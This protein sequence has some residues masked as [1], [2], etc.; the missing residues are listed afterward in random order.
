MKQKKKIQEV[1]FCVDN[2]IRDLPSTV[3]ICNFLSIKN[4]K[5]RII[6]IGEE[7]NSTYKGHCLF[8]YP[9][10]TYSLIS[11]ITLKS[12]GH[13]VGVLEVEGNNQD[14]EI[15]YKVRITPDFWCFWNEAEYKKYIYLSKENLYL[16]FSGCQ[17]LDLL[18]TSYSHIFNNLKK[19][20][21]I[22]VLTIALSSQDTHF[23]SEKL[24]YKTERRRKKFSKAA[25]YEAVV[26]N[27]LELRNR[28][29]KLIK[30]VLENT[31]LQIILRP[32]PNENIL[33]W[34]EFMKKLD[35][36]SIKLSLDEYF[37]SFI[38]KSDLHLAFN[39]CTTTVEA[40]LIGLKTIELQT[41]ESKKLYGHEHLKLA[42]YNSLS[43]ESDFKVLMSL[44]RNKNYEEK[45][46]IKG[47]NDFDFNLYVESKY[48]KFDGLRCKEI[49]KEIENFISRSFKKKNLFFYKLFSQLI[50]LFSELK[51]LINTKYRR[52]SIS[53]QNAEVIDYNGINLYKN[54]GIISSNQLK[55]DIELWRNLL[56]N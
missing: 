46:L 54:H 19:S 14:K 7:L 27:Q 2:K 9:K 26:K 48:G 40:R 33:Y 39:V 50:L 15:E 28:C 37:N 20:R 4:I 49:S 47:I 38:N 24:K 3:Q 16:C 56:K 52:Q 51:K 8:I 34:I 31:D 53:R 36:A 23:N 1:I 42:N 18:H 25:D 22:K 55:N 45:S 35:N 17:R 11:V 21:D 5:N 29:E 43:E 32:H 44:I 30:K 10:V 12:L 41:E 13:F 6:P